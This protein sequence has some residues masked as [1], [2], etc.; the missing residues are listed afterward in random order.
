MNYNKEFY[1]KLVLNGA[2]ILLGLC[3]AFLLSQIPFRRASSIVPIIPFMGIGIDSGVIIIG[4][5]CCTVIW[6]LELKDGGP[7]LLKKPGLPA[8]PVAKI[9]DVQVLRYQSATG[10]PVSQIPARSALAEEGNHYLKLWILYSIFLLIILI[11]VWTEIP[12]LTNYAG[13][14]VIGVFLIGLLPLISFET[15][16]K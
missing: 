3:I 9:R 14:I 12:M 10:H 6:Y 1:I 11:G 4:F 2:L 16:Y 5:S 13:W 7:G 8:Y 15:K